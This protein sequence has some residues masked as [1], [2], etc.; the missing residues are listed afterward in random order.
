MING[1][2]DRS[3]TG[4]TLGSADFKSAVSAIP[5]HRQITRLEY[6]RKIFQAIFQII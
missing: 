1:A 2:G 3:R 4:T 5:P 6:V